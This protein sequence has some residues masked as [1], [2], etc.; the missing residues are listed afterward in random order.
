MDY[1]HY[2]CDLG[3]MS[4]KPTNNDMYGEQSDE[5]DVKVAAQEPIK[6]APLP[7]AKLPDVCAVSI[8]FF[9]NLLS[10][11]MLVDLYLATFHAKRFLVEILIL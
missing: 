3:K 6:P 2:A 10:V 8:W 9:K 11:E 1:S 4:E 5:E 7:K